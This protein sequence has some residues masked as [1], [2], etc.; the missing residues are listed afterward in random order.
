MISIAEGKTLSV[1]GCH[2]SALFITATLAAM[3]TPASAHVDYYVLPLRKMVI[4][5][6]H[7]MVCCAGDKKIG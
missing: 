6:Y 5:C 2:L 7:L 1:Y 4:V 3:Y